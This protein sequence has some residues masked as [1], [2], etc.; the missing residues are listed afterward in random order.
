MRSKR[1]PSRRSLAA[2]LV[3]AGTL[4]GAVALAAPSSAAPS[5]A[6]ASRPE[7]L[8]GSDAPRVPTGTARA[9]VLGSSQ[10][11]TVDV[12]L[13]LNNQAKLTSLLSGL[14]SPA[15]PYYHDFLTPAEFNAAFGP[16]TQQV[17]D[18]ESALRADGLTP[19][20]A[21]QDRLSIP[22]TATAAQLEHAFGVT[23]ATYHLPGGRAAYANTAAPS[24]QQDAAPYVTGILGLN[25]LYQA[26][27]AAEPVAADAATGDSA[28]TAAL[29]S[30][31]SAA[32]T[33]SVAAAAPKACAAGTQ[34]PYNAGYPLSKFASYYGLSWLYGLGD[35]GQG[36]RI[37][38]LELQP[39]VHGDITAFEKCYGISTPV[40]YTQVGAN[41]N[42]ADYP[43]ADSTEAP[44][45]IEVAA[46]LAPR[47][48]I[49]VLQATNTASSF[50]EVINKFVAA[51]TD[52][53]LSISWGL[54]ENE[55]SLSMM[56]SVE[57]LIEKADAQG[58]TVV[59]AAGDDGATDC[60]EEGANGIIDPNNTLSVNFPASSPYAISVGGTRTTL[61]GNN[62]VVWNE[63]DLFG[64]AGGGGISTTCM[65]G[66]QD[67]AKVPGVINPGDA[68]DVDS[69]ASCPTGHYRE[70]PDV[71]ADAD[72]LTGYI[73]YIHGQGGWVPFG[74][75]S[76][77]TPLLAAV[78]AL[79]DA[80][81]FCAGYGSGSAGLLPQ[82]LYAAVAGSSSYV[83]GATTEVLRDVS[84]GN[85]DYT[86]S[87]DYSGD[88]SAGHGFD[89][90]SGLGAP[91][92]P[93]YRGGLPSTYNPG[94]TALMCRQLAT[95]KLKIGGIAGAGP[96]N[97]AV[98]VA[99][100]AT[101]LLP[102]AGADLVRVYK[103]ATLLA[104][105]APPCTASDCTVTLPKEPAG[106]VV[107]LA[108]STED[109]LYTSPVA[110]SPLTFVNAP[111]ITTISPSRGTIN[112]GTR[113]TIKGANFVGVKSVTF[114]GKAGTHLSVSGTGTL[115]VIAPKGPA[116]VRIKVV[117]NAVGGTSN[118]VLYTY[119]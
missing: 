110:A 32:S 64:G 78:A 85:N 98:K 57:E 102:V 93:G 42:A 94:L 103:G 54:C 48:S 38:L 53:T 95:R 5:A 87:G 99:L 26:H 62:E 115:T 4:L 92:V 119:A 34:T 88:Y 71:S 109:G 89:L 39:T 72:P 70:V 28:S 22:V 58:Q 9:G 65:P 46:A 41:F 111:H 66:Y 16:T 19:G 77:A 30:T 91:V 69:A 82:A 33:A 100:H 106:T 49:D 21:S 73:V 10:L 6:D 27:S 31:M 37:A 13:G 52:K 60:F 1:A 24:I 3:A 80:S 76:A 84:N 116:K 14:A 51:D 44:L 68:T 86:P 35:E 25:D 107:S 23:L 104:T 2:C 83:Y 55:T 7:L 90:A 56:T 118:W 20:P 43:P 59:A 11:L 67:Q 113:V 36:S 8:R 117:V 61:A 17:D 47:A 112:G 45:D 40:Y 18:V 79:T 74:G 97:T 63:S 96:A 12:T 81:P 29:A 15:S 101:G 108:V 105:S 50:Y 75:T 114:N